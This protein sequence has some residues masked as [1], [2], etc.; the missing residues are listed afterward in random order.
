MEVKNVSSDSGS[1]VYTPKEHFPKLSP[2]RAPAG[3]GGR[4]IKMCFC[5]GVQRSRGAGTG[6]GSCGGNSQ[7]EPLKC[8]GRGGGQEGEGEERI[9]A[10]ELSSET[11]AWRRNLIWGPENNV[12]VLKK[13]GYC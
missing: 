12:S 4:I 3:I 9:L 5:A 13:P 11:V 2:R 7:V 6:W 10:L 8:E 1:G